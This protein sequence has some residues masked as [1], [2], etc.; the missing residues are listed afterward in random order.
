MLDEKQRQDFWE[1]ESDPAN[2]V[3]IMLGYQIVTIDRLLSGG[4]DVGVFVE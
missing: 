3:L 4:I 2:E 1:R